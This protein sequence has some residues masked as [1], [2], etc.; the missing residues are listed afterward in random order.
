MADNARAGRLDIQGD[1][2]RVFVGRREYAKRSKRGKR[3]RMLKQRLVAIEILLI[4][5]LITVWEFEG[6]NG[7]PCDM[8]GTILIAVL[9]LYL[10]F[11]KECWVYD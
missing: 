9:A 11:T 2:R 7:I 5:V 4:C 10:L 1:N 3:L 8:C 6:N